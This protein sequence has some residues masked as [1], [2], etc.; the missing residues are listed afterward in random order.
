[1]FTTGSQKNTMAKTAAEN[2]AAVLNRSIPISLI[3][4]LKDFFVTGG[5]GTSVNFSALSASISL[6]GEAT[7]LLVKINVKAATI[8]NIILPNNIKDQPLQL[9]GL[10]PNLA[11][12][13]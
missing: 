5:N 3:F 6:N 8:H 7:I 1:M 2:A 9:P 13:S 4:C 11:A 10:K 12:Y